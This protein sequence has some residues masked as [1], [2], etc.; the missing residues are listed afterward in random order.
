[1][2]LEEDLVTKWQL[3]TAVYI[4]QLVLATMDIIPNKLYLTV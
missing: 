2:N 3:H 1:M 4:I